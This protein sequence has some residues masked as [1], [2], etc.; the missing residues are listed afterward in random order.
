MFNCTL[1]K[2]NVYFTELCVTITFRHILLLLTY[3]QKCELQTKLRS[4]G[5]SK[6]KTFTLIAQNFVTQVAYE[7]CLNS[8]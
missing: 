6:K 5:A 7:T 8:F 1:R 2:Y 3:E 4:V